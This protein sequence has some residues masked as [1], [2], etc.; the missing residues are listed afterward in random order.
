MGYKKE[1]HM[2]KKLHY[3]WIVIFMGLFTTV[4]A[5]GF[6]QALLYLLSSF[7]MIL[8]DGDIHGISWDVS[9]YL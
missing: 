5:H 4:A 8:M 9:F 7:P 2:E 1:K 6:C 3:G